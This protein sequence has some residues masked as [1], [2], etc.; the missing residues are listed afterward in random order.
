MKIKW[1][2]HE[3]ILVSASAAI[4]STS[5]LWHLHGTDGNKYAGAFIDNNVSFSLFK[6]LILPDVGIGLLIYLL[7]LWINI[8]TIPHVSSSKKTLLIKCVSLFVQFVIIIFLLGVA[9]DTATYL[10][11]EWQFHY[12][13][14]SIFFNEHISNPQLNLSAGFFDASAV[15]F[16]YGLYTCVREV[17]ITRIATSKQSKYNIAVLNRVTSFALILIILYLL[18]QAF[19][20]IHEQ[21]FFAYYFLII[22][23][24]AATFINNVYW[25]FPK[26][27]N[28]SFFSKKIIIPLLTT[29]LVYALPLMVIIHEEAP[30]AFLCSWAVQLFI[31]TP[32]TWLYYQSN[33]DKILQLRIVE[34]E[35]G[36]S[37]ANL[38]FLRSQINPH[39]LFNVLN[40]LYGTA[41]QEN[42]ERTAEGIQKLGDMMRFMLH[43]HN[44]DFIQ[45]K[46]EIDYLK[47]YIA[48]QKLRTQTS[49][50]IVI[51]D[52]IIEQNCTHQI[53]PMLLIPLVE[54][55][56]KHG[57]S[58]KQKS[59]IKINL[60][61]TEKEIL[62]EVTNSVHN[63]EK[64]DPE[65]DTSGIGYQN[66]LERLKLIY[67]ERFQ[68]SVNDNGKEFFVK[69]SIQP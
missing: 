25:L 9:I 65:R 55:A 14:F 59:W 40:T 63:K 19:N 34:K 31:A 53:A 3:M 61:C 32:I 1:R 16:S 12:P 21:E 60:G 26:K 7:Y 56:F 54:N 46:K 49:P 10:G 4:L 15:L 36:K 30:V 37:N 44:L 18:L 24:I 5:Y 20:L 11:H 28:D 29:S 38:Q 50:D 17:S 39:F 48:L 6:N 64:N 2:H 68:I 66:V 27:G 62:F 57:I 33:K 13:G 22:P 52:N 35:L 42:A 47:N 43:E 51:E 58:L 23:A 69:L 67:P 45:M 41:L 8:Y